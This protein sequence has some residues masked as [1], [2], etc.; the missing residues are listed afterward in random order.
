MC[1]YILCDW[2]R[3]DIF[4]FVYSKSSSQEFNFI[5]K[6]WNLMKCEGIK[7]TR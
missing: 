7:S 2:N 4:I 6:V 1:D 3:V 5:A